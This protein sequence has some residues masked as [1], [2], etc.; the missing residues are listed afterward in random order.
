[1]ATDTAVQ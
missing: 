1:M